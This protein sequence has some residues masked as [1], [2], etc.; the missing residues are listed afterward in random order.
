MVIVGKL[1]KKFKN[2]FSRDNVPEKIF[3]Q[4]TS[5]KER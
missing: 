2:L 4:I 5:L 1:V 3:K